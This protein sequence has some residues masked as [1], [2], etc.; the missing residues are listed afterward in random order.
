TISLIGPYQN[1]W[2]GSS[3]LSSLEYADTSRIIRDI[4]NRS[5]PE[6]IIEEVERKKGEW[7]LAL[8]L[9]TLLPNLEALELSPG[10]S[11]LPNP[12]LRSVSLIDTDVEYPYS[13]DTLVPLFS[14]P[15][16]TEISSQRLESDSHITDDSLLPPS[17]FAN[18][19]TDHRS[20]VETLH[21][22]DCKLSERD[23]KMLLRLPKSLRSFIYVH[24]RGN[25]GRLSPA[26]V[27]R[28]P[29]HVSGTLNTLIMKFDD[30]LL[31]SVQALSF[32][33]FPAL[34]TLTINYKLLYGPNL[35]DIVD[36]LPLSL[37]AL[38][39]HLP[40][41]PLPEDITAAESITTFLSKRFGG[42]SGE[43]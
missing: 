32:A 7:A 36:R 29:D 19:N 21:L 11:A 27:R 35:E 25:R 16:I 5:L 6:E 20:T 2:W 15:S 3:Y 28:A 30:S 34:K 26:Q 43:L 24:K 31:E 38:D 8:C 13:V 17:A 4:R 23:L 12:S 40:Y 10:G 18:P 1:L 9:L 41:V 14:F 39:L 33:D 37:E 22:Y 42:A